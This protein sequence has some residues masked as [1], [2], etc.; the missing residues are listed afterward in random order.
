MMVQQQQKERER[1]IY[2]R[3]CLIYQAIEIH[4][5][6]L[7]SFLNKTFKK[8]ILEFGAMQLVFSNPFVFGFSIPN[9]MCS[10]S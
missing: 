4:S 7:D 6:K 2:V 5:E 10:M 8:C 9:H 3:R 1:K